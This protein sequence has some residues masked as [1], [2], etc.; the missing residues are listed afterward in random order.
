M[1]GSGSAL[2]H[3][4][5]YERIYNTTGIRDED[6]FYRWIVRLVRPAPGAQMLDVACGE[7]VLVELMRQRSVHS[8][9]ID[10]SESALTR[11]R[12]CFPTINLVEGDAEKLPYRSAIFDGVT[13]LGSLEN[14]EHPVPAL[15]EIRRVLKDDG[16]FVTMLPNKYFLGDLVRIVFGQ[17]EWAP[18]QDVERVASPRQWR[19]FLELHG[20]SVITSYGYV[21]KSPLFKKG[22]LRSIPKFLKTR[23]LAMICPPT[24]AWC[25]VYL[26]R[27]ARVSGNPK[28]REYGWLW[29]AEYATEH[30]LFER[31]SDMSQE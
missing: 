10:I 1:S 15:E 11:G 7:G 9:G 5:M 28:P 22:K 18:F 4:A 27:K 2:Q 20:F 23:C 3:K 8:H 31:A 13:C 21:K 26:C 19:R 24:L 25:V 6:E 30:G 12:R 16:I 14:L 17:E 29:K